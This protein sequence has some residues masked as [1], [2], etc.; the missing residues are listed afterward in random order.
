MPCLLLSGLCLR[1]ERGSSGTDGAVAG[2]L[3]RHSIAAVLPGVYTAAFAG[4]CGV[5]A[6]LPII[7]SI[8]FL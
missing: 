3:C 8:T 2:S 6:A 1:Y 4:C 5:A 7:L